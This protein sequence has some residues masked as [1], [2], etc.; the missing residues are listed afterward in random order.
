[1]YPLFITLAVFKTH[2][3]GVDDVY[4]QSASSKIRVQDACLRCGRCEQPRYDVEPCVR[5]GRL[6]SM[7][8]RPH[9]FAAQNC[10]PATILNHTIEIQPHRPHGSDVTPQS[11]RGLHSPRHVFVHTVHMRHGIERPGKE[12]S[13]LSLP[14]FGSQSRSRKSLGKESSVNSNAKSMA[15]VLGNAFDPA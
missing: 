4:S 14:A 10:A 15:G 11:G 3:Y 1:M 5:C 2:V 13:T 8:I 6:E 7:H 12:T 9:L